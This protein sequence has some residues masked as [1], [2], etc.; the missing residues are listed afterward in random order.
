MDDFTI[1]I[2][3]REQEPWEFFD[4]E[5]KAHALQTG[6]YT[7]EGCADFLCIERKKS[8]GELNKN[9]VTPRF[10]KELDRMLDFKY[11][12]LILEFSIDD[13][14]NFP[15][16]SNIPK[17]IWKK[18]KVTGRYMLKRLAE[19][20]IDYNVRVLPCGTRVA[21]QHMAYNIMRHMHEK[22]N[23]T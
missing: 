20:E 7:I 1:L 9:I 22:Y 5:T 4:V 19:I 6:D 2:D 18:L 13:I 14:L 23:T 21:A 8:A 16:G 3:T 17:H 11:A 15:V 10:N 12:Y